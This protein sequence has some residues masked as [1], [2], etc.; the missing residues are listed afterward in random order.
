MKYRLDDSKKRNG[1]LSNL[2]LPPWSF[3]ALVPKVNFVAPSPFITK[4][5]PGH[6]MRLFSTITTGERIAISFEFS[7]EM[8][9]NSITNALS[10][11][12]TARYN[13]TAQFDKATVTC[14]PI[15]ETPVASWPGAASSVFS[16]SIEL[17]NV[18]HGVHEII[19][20]NA[21]TADGKR[22]TNVS[23]LLKILLFLF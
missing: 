1:C 8:D 9:C 21:T 19:I 23:F 11:Y 16:Y 7:Q 10:V 22:H 13:E 4:F 6:D 12:S 18:F 15:P 5:V 20:N 2:Q 3:K 14:G 17:S